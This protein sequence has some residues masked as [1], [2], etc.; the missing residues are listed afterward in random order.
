MS[1]G[2][3]PAFGYTA[4]VHHR[5]KRHLLFFMMLILPL[6]AFASVTLLG[7]EFARLG[8]EAAP[9]MDMAGMPHAIGDCHESAPEQ[10]GAPADEHQCSHCAAC[11]LAGAFPLPAAVTTAV[12]PIP[13]T[14]HLRT[15]EPFSGFI[16]EGPERPPRTSLV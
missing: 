11:Y 12:A 4:R 15:A 14:P 9:V 2:D 6:Q 8:G 1:V 5:F 13:H 3:I 16:P 10:S 7:C